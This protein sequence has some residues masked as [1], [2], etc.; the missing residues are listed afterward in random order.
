MV[1]YS[2]CSWLH[3]ITMNTSDSV[4]EANVWIRKDL[5]FTLFVAQKQNPLS[6]LLKWFD[7]IGSCD[8]VVSAIYSSF[9]KQ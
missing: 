3:Y 2:T 1:L 6:D 7:S 8:F 4:L 5:K 9:H